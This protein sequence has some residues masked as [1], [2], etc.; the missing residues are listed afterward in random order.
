MRNLSRFFLTLGVLLILP[1]IILYFIMQV[2]SFNIYWIMIIICIFYLIGIYENPKGKI[3]IRLFFY[4]LALSNILTVYGFGNFCHGDYN[5]NIFGQYF[6]I[7]LR[8][9]LYKDFNFNQ[10]TLYLLGC[11]GLFL[12]EVSCLL[13]INILKRY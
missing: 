9:L 11:V 8:A 7:N 5:F 13:E 3:K 1:H 10:L 4:S 2:Y 6:C 12:I